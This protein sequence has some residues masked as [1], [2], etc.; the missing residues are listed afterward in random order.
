VRFHHYAVDNTVIRIRS[1]YRPSMARLGRGTWVVREL[2]NG[3]W[4]MPACP[5]IT[6]G[7]LKSL[8]YLGSVPVTPTKERP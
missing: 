1:R 8:E 6:W 2:A 4:I 5:E 7:T 3:E